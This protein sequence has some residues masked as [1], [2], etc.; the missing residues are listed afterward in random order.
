VAEVIELDERNRRLEILIAEFRIGL[1]AEFTAA[2]DKCQ[3]ECE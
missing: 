3:R 1:L 2:G